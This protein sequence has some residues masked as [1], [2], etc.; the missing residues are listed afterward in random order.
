MLGRMLQSVLWGCLLA[1]SAVE[2]RALQEQAR[3]PRA[4]PETCELGRVSRV[5]VDNRDIFD[6]DEVRGAPF[7]WAFSLANRLHVRTRAS[8]LRRE[9]LFSVNDCYDPFLVAD[10]ERLLRRHPFI[11]EVEVYGIQQPDRTWHV[12]VDTRDDW[13]TVFEATPEFRDGFRITRAEAREDNFLGRGMVL[14]AFFRERD[15][16]RA[17]GVQFRTP[18]LFNTRTDAQVRYGE[19]RVGTL[20]EAELFHP[21]VGEIGNTAWRQFFLRETD[22]FSYSTGAPGDGGFVLLPVQDRRVEFT[23]ARRM[24][25]PGNLTMLGLGVSRT[26]LRFDVGP[27]GIQQVARRAFG[28]PQP[29][30]PEQIEA[31]QPQTL[32]FEGTRLNLLLGQRNIDFA[33]RRGLDALRG[34]HDLEVGSELALTLGRTVGNVGGDIP[35]DIYTRFRLYAAGTPGEFVV[36]SSTAFEGRQIFASER[37]PGGWRD[38]MAEGDLLVYWQ[39]G[40]A[41]RHTFFGRATG[42]GGWSLL[43][44]FQ[45]TL[46]G[47]QGVRGHRDH[48]FPGAQRLVFSA[49]DRVYLGWPFPDL[50]D[51]GATI[52]ADI[53]RIWAGDVPFGADSGWRGTIGAGLRFGFPEGSR[54]VIRVD[55]AWPVTAGFGPRD[56]VFRISFGDLIGFTQGLE[57]L[58]LARSRRMTVGPDQFSP[59]RVFR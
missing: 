32:F 41:P 48:E 56:V 44:P 40:A 54:G 38:V 9:L 43:Q 26:E 25:K 55:A 5:F 49:E 10:S 18:R 22:V 17:L 20:L 51:L 12:I 58:Q 21:F 37:Y 23:F 8:F 3:R 35:D 57:D 50:F 4:V 7:Q 46:G 59:Q 31:L 47:P 39:P 36:V 42:A 29:A 52:F 19:T 27:D 15:A 13:T 11:A 53:G 2:G 24:G 1:A 33:Q 30:T 14:G 45:L 28:D 6:L 34:L 16:Q